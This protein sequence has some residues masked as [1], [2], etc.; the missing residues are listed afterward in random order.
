MRYNEWKKK[1]IYRNG[2]FYLLK[3]SD[4]W[5]LSCQDIPL[6]LIQE[7]AQTK[8]WCK[9]DPNPMKNED[10]TIENFD[11]GCLK[12]NEQEVVVRLYG[13]GSTDEHNIIG[14]DAEGD[15]SILIKD[16]YI[17][18]KEVISDSIVRIKSYGRC[19]RIG[20]EFCTQGI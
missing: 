7:M 17:Q 11:E 12:G 3:P 14:F 13:P 2:H 10:I 18:S 19:D 16:V 1:E 9:D 6:E 5:A 15:F 20:T 4:I 8:L